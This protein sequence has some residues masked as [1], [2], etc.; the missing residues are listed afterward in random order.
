M[1]VST[2]EALQTAIDRD[3][4]WRKVELTL[5]KTNILSINPPDSL[6]SSVLIRSAITMLYAHWEG[7][8]KNMANKYLSHVSSLHLPCSQLKMNFFV[9][10]IKNRM[11]IDSDSNQ[12]PILSA[13]VQNILSTYNQP[14]RIPTKGAI[15]TNANLTSSI[16]IQ[17]MLTLGLDYS[18][19]ETKFHLIDADLVEVRNSI[20]HGDKYSKL[21]SK[22]SYIQIHEAV[23]DLI[24]K[25]SQQIVDSA[26]NKGYLK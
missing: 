13:L 17:I 7:A 24:S 6:A 5:I 23:T 18:Q 19:Y 4:S 1:G 12:M 11:R 9:L 3:I 10:S 15:S 25:I 21:V 14:S 16:F 26:I 22:D 2:V 20:A 8:I